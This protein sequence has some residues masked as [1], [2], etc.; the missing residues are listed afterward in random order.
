MVLSILG[1]VCFH[2]FPVVFWWLDFPIKAGDTI[3]PDDLEDV[4]WDEITNCDDPLRCGAKAVWK[5]IGDTWNGGWLIYTEV[6]STQQ[7]WE[8]TS[9]FI[10]WLTNYALWII[11]LVALVYLLYHGMMAVTAWADEEKLKKWI[12]WA[13]YAMIAIFWIA[14]AWFMISL[15][16]WLIWLLTQQ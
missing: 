8:Q 3:L 1:I 12:G 11:W 6:E 10:K 7:S 4:I 9:N 13:K 15:V 5:W 14:V 16:F 2:S